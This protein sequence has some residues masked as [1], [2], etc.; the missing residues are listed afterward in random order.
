MG[1][2]L[3]IEATVR[4]LK[5]PELLYK[6]PSFAEVPCGYKRGWSLL[7]SFTLQVCT[8]AIF[9]L[10]A[11]YTVLQHVITIRPQLEALPLPSSSIVYL[12]VLGGGTEGTGA[13]GGGSGSAEAPSSGVRAQSRRGFAYP[14]P[15]PM[16]SNPPRASLGIQTIQQPSLENLPSSRRFVE[17]PNIVQQPPA[18]IAHEKPLLVK[19]EE[20]AHNSQPQKPIAPPKI[21]MPAAPKGKI[22]GL[23]ESKSQLPHKAV[24]DAVDASQAPTISD[25]KGGL[26]VLNAVPPAPD[27][28]GKIPRA[29]ERSLFAVSPAEATIIADP[30]AGTKSGGAASMPAGSGGPTEI[31]SGDALAEI[32][33]GGNTTK[34]EAAGSGTGTGG[35][36]GNDRG[37]GLNSSADAAGTGRGSGASSGLGTG[38][39]PGGGSGKGGGSAPGAGGFSGITIQGGQYG[40]TGNPLVKPHSPRQTS[41]NMT[42]VSTAGSGGGLPDFGVFRNEKVY[43]VY[44]DMR[45]SDDDPAPAWTLQYSVLP[46]APKSGDHPAP[47]SST[48]TPP[49]ATLK[50]VPQLTPD[51][52]R[53]YARRSIVVSG[54][55]DA[56]GK[57][58]DLSVKQPVENQFIRPIVEALQDWL[59]EPAKIEG[60]PVALKVLL[61]IRLA[62]TR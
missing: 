46:S 56:Q 20:L 33:S 6:P 38:A 4:E 42:I 2:L 7:S 9:L 29:E 39:T 23:I 37:R 57:L 1:A 54:I 31:R 18:E 24:P 52:I 35:H 28:S 21:S 34:T 36:Y 32:A 41:Y 8:V 40:N 27:I 19:P 55:L 45:S 43:T 61:G 58:Q 62:A 50:T 47:N 13:L 53:Q 17:L 44:L 49:Y 25:K 16:I 14:G 26:L 5:K 15:Q 10:F 12:P 3:D 22:A 48:P 60:Q 51:V 30:S 11:R 59:F